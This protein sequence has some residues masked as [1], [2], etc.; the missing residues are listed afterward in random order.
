MFKKT[1][2][3]AGQLYK[4]AFYL[5]SLVLRT[6]FGNYNRH[7]KLW[8]GKYFDVDRRTEYEKRHRDYKKLNFRTQ[9]P[10]NFDYHMSEING[11]FER[12]KE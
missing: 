6:D 8:H 1:Y 5:K 7:Y 12:V 11:G 9:D 3:S 2:E 10:L 4:K